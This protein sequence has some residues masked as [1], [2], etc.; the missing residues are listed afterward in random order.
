MGT[1]IAA[2]IVVGVTLGFVVGRRWAEYF[3]IIATG[4]FI[5]FEA[6]ELVQRVTVL[7]ASA[8]ALNVAVVAYLIV[9]LKHSRSA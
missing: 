3:T 9:H 4:S 5:P 7:R 6:Y 2:G 1:L 8:L